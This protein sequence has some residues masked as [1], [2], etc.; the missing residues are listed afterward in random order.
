M[1]PLS[2]EFDEVT[3]DFTGVP[4]LR[5]SRTVHRTL[6]V[7]LANKSQFNARC[8]MCETYIVKNHSWVKRLPEPLR[9][10]YPTSR[11]HPRWYVH[12][13]CYDSAIEYLIETV[14]A[15][16]MARIDARSRKWCCTPANPCPSW[17]H[18]EVATR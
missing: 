7:P 9:P 10:I 5:N 14:P 4:A 15:E 12:E 3:I 2:N 18:G 1:A 8:P 13:Y 16:E 6:R 17:L 11:N